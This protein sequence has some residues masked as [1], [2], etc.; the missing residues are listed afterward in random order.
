VFLSHLLADVLENIVQAMMREIVFI[1]RLHG[2]DSGLV[3]GSG[4][5]CPGVTPLDRRLFA[6][7]ATLPV[8]PVW[9]AR[10]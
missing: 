4:S 1:E 3:K 2:E 5:I 8:L 7:F 6:G 9:L 10:R